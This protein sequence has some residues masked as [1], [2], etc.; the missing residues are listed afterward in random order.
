M[1][2]RVLGK[3]APDFIELRVDDM[4]AAQDIAETIPERLGADYLA[5]DWAN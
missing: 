5:Q 1:A 2:Q 3:S 4:F